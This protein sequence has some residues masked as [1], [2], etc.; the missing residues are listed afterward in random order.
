MRTCIYQLAASYPAAPAAVSTH[1]CF[2]ATVA[3]GSSLF[4]SPGLWAGVRLR[5]VISL[6]LSLSLS[7]HAQHSDFAM[8]AR[9]QNAR[10]RERCGV[11]QAKI[12]AVYGTAASSSVRTMAQ[13][14]CSRFWTMCWHISITLRASASCTAPVIRI[15]ALALALQRASSPWWLRS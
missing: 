1:A 12:E 15:R 11:I 5:G 9:L 8:H 7:R 3:A 4:L 10:M 14:T 13:V 6:S 2:D